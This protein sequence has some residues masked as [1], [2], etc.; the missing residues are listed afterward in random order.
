M[1]SH[2]AFLSSLKLPPRWWLSPLG[3]AL[4]FTLLGS[5]KPMHIDETAN[6]YYAA[7]IA[8]HPLDPFGFDI[9]W[10]QEPE[11]ANEVLTPPMMVSWWALG[12]RLFR[13]FG[14][15]PMLWKLWLWPFTFLFVFSLYLLLRR[16]ARGMETPLLWMTVLAPAILPGLNLM[17]DIPE[18]AFALAAL[19]VFLHAVEVQGKSAWAWAGLAGLLAG[20]AMQSKYTG[21]LAPAILGLA[22]LCFRR[23]R[24]WPLVAVVAVLVFAGWEYVTFRLYGESHFLHQLRYSSQ[25]LLDKLELVGPLFSIVGGVAPVVGL[26]ALSALHCRRAHVVLAGGVVLLGYGIV[27]LVGI[28]FT[29]QTTAEVLNR[30]AK[31]VFF[32]FSLSDVIY[33]GW[34]IAIFSLLVLTALRLCQFRRGRGKELLRSWQRR[35]IAWFLVLWL[36]LEVVGYFFLTPFPAVRRVMGIVIVATLLTGQL[37]SRTCRARQQRR[38]IRGL[39]IFNVLL[40]L[41]FLGVDIWDANAQKRGA[42]AA[43]QLVRA[44]GGGT[45]WYVGHWGFQYYAEHEGMKPVAPPSRWGRTYEP[46]HLKAGDWLILP[47]PRIDQQT[48]KLDPHQTKLIDTWVANDWLPLR[49]SSNYYGGWTPL[50]HQQ[51]PRLEVEVRKVLVDFVPRSR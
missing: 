12:V 14:E 2:S 20:L 4:L 8:D 10:Y 38:L 39:A 25:S 44:N 46:S 24:L 40:G 47:D 50:E 45:I 19:V 26:L 49:T 30:P 31:V 42:E 29:G 5:L 7:H 15:Q 34:G 6:Y 11:P 17:P 37:A 9:F 23:L 43:A 51:G 27:A 48:I 36:A 28:S 3:L 1:I 41:G 33:A 13:P 35:P 32:F 22:A 18:L 16:V 21:F